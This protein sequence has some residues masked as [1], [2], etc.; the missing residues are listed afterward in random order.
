M[1]IQKIGVKRVCLDVQAIMIII[2]TQHQTVSCV[3]T[4][5]KKLNVQNLVWI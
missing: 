2:V 5:V 3:A 1:V 4:M